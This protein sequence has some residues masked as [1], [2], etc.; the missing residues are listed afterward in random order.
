MNADDWVEILSQPLP[1][2]QAIAFA[3]CPAGGGMSVFLG[4]TRQEQSADGRQ[5]AA[6]DYHAYEQMA[7]EQMQQLACRARQNWPVVKLVLLHR[8]GRVPLGQPSVLIAVTTPHRQQAF[9][10]CRFLIDELKKLA[11]I[12]KQQVWSDGSTCWV[13]SP[14]D[15][16]S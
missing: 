4:M 12:W 3:A 10:A 16:R 14:P 15:Q 8:V 1:I 2:E 6:L 13:D 11:P 9:A 5:L 7:L